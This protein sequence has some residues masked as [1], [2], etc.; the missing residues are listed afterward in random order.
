[1]SVKGSGSADALVGNIHK[2]VK[3]PVPE[4]YHGERSKLKGFLIQADL[5]L[6]F[7]GAHFSSDTERV[8]WVVTLLRGAALNWIEGYIQ[9]YMKNTNAK[10][11]ITTAMRVDTQKMF[12]TYKGFILRI[13][14][15]FGEVDEEKVAERAI[16][17]LRQKGSAATYTAEFQRYSTKTG[18][19]DDALRAQY[20][21]GLKDFVKDELVRE[22][23]AESLEELITTAVKIDNRNYERALERKGF[24][25]PG[26]RQRAPRNHDNS[27][28]RPMEL[29]VAT[30]KP[31]LSPQDKEKH[32]RNRTCF[33][34]GKPGHMAR[35][36][37]TSK[38][39]P[40]NTGKRGQLNATGVYSGPMQLNATRVGPAEE[41]W[42]TVTQSMEA[43][44]F[45]ETEGNDTNSSS[46][47]SDTENELLH[48]EPLTQSEEIELQRRMEDAENRHWEAQEK[49][50]KAE[51]LR[52]Q[53][54]QLHQAQQHI[55][56]LEQ[57]VKEKSNQAGATQKELEDEEK[58][59]FRIKQV[60]FVQEVVSWIELSEQLKDKEKEAKWLKDEVAELKRTVLGD[61]DNVARTDHPKHGQLWW[62]ACYTNSCPLHLAPK[63][64]EGFFPDREEPVYWT[65]GY[66]GQDMQLSKN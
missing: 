8:L 38:M 30:E 10:G 52:K 46:T 36:C 13:N 4:S 12:G 15:T 48:I 29:D 50:E 6:T 51:G 53:E 54:A 43:L 7:H 27:W 34:C 57:R 63:K 5:Y 62:R 3:I 41:D 66:E 55:T 56:E 16:Q 23:K 20:Y 35:N 44:R 59:N 32:M 45:V 11:Q 19:N 42:E 22:D 65:N 31:R 60:K 21:R 18:W 49:G 33:N 1:M 40:N 17:T 9:D 61:K 25:D 39:R 28:P 58:P 24:Y 47:D 37:K 2:D 26:Y 64:R 14:A